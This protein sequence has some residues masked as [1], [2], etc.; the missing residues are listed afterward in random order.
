MK[1]AKKTVSTIGISLKKW[2]VAS[3]GRT[4]FMSEHSSFVLKVVVINIL[5]EFANH[6]V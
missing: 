5:N 2:F 4:T 3:T 6:C 1:A